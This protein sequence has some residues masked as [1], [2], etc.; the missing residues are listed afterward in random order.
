MAPSAAQ[1]PLSQILLLPGRVERDGASSR[2]SSPLGRRAPTPGWAILAT[3][4]KK[5][6]VGGGCP[7]PP[8]PLGFYVD[9]RIKGRGDGGGGGELLLLVGQQNS[10]WNQRMSVG[11]TRGDIC[12]VLTFQN[13]N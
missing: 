1:E 6:K 7:W 8:Q 9:K 5:G 4:L 10:L 13:E 3:C 11:Q 12:N 2:S